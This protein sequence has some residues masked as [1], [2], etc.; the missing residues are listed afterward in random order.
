M[1]RVTGAC[2]GSR[3]LS[4]GS[5]IELLILSLFPSFLQKTIT[6]TLRLPVSYYLQEVGS[7]TDNKLSKCKRITSARQTTNPRSSVVQYYKGKPL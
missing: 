4:L 1:G 3:K 5:K 2:R 7:K 6:I